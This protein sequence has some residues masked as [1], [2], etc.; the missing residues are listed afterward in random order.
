[1]LGISITDVQVH[2]TD[3]LPTDDGLAVVMSYK[4][5]LS[6]KISAFEARANM[7]TTTFVG[8]FGHRLKVLLHAKGDG[9]NTAT[10]VSPMHVADATIQRITHAP[11]PKPKPVLQTQQQESAMAPTSAILGPTKHAASGVG[12]GHGPVWWSGIAFVLAG[13]IC[14]VTR[15]LRSDA[16][17]D[18]SS[19]NVPTAGAIALQVSQKDKDAGELTAGTMTDLGHAA[20]TGEYGYGAVDPDDGFTAALPQS[21]GN[22]ISIAFVGDADTEV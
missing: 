1:M 17:Y 7:H 6:D 5:D 3:Y 21:T 19:G 20:G 12:H 8:A 15:T 14:V 16:E 11:T 4:I 13:T 18:T 2:P 10:L 9:Y 22:D